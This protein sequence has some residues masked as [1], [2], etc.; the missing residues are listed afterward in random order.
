MA[1]YYLCVNEK[2]QLIQVLVL[3]GTEIYVEVKGFDVNNLFS[4]QIV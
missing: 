4:G 2:G 1:S 3:D